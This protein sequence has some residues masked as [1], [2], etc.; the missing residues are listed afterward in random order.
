MTKH[1]LLPLV[2]LLAALTGRVAPLQA[3]S[4]ELARYDD[5][6]NSL[7]PQD[8]T[9]AITPV[10][11]GSVI[12]GAGIAAGWSSNGQTLFA[13]AAKSDGARILPAG[14]AST[15]TATDMATVAQTGSYFEFKLTPA[16]GQSLSLTGF[17]AQV[18]AERLS[19]SDGSDTPAFTAQF[20]LLSS[21]DNFTNPLATARSFVGAGQTSS[22]ANW[23]T[24]DTGA[25]DDSFTRLTQ[26][27]TFRLYVYTGPT[28]ADTNQVA[29]IDDIVISGATGSAIPE[30]ATTAVMFSGAA[31]FIAILVRRVRK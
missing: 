28:S 12:S 30:P 4:G 11:F 23:V 13:R 1:L 22:S 5:K 18:R 17:N 10:T 6:T 25:L 2:A 9:Y 27:V 19:R 14:T 15:N 16:E 3:A 31:L 20:F 8:D 24:L 26:S 21:V 29:R 7:T